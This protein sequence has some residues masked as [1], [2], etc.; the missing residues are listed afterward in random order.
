M[1]KEEQEYKSIKD[2]ADKLKIKH[3][4]TLVE[5]KLRLPAY[6]A[7][8]IKV[9]AAVDQKSVNQWVK[10]VT[11]QHIETRTEVLEDIKLLQAKVAIINSQHVAEKTNGKGFEMEM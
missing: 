9:A 4:E 2:I 7:T 1:A 3:D 6:E 5:L 10:E 11:M 8:A